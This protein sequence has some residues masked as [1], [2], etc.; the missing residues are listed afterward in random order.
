MLRCPVTEAFR[1][2]V[3]A[4]NAVCNYNLAIEERQNNRAVPSKCA[5]VVP[6][7][8]PAQTPHLQSDALAAKISF[9]LLFCKTH[10]SP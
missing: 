2:A 7:S 1:T 3:R 9:T 8:M 10:G 6:E 4:C 5:C